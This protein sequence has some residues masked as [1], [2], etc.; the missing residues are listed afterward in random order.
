MAGVLRLFSVMRWRDIERAVSRGG[1][2]VY[3][4]DPVLV[5]SCLDGDERAWAELVQHY[6]RLVYSL[7][8]RYGLS[9]A[10][11]ED[12]LQ[13]VFSIVLRELKTLRNYTRLSGWLITITHHETFRQKS[14][15]RQAGLEE[16]PIVEIPLS[17]DDVSRWEREELMR[18][19]L[20]RLAP[21]E[22]EIVMSVFA[23]DPPSHD[24]LA[25]RL[26][27]PRGSIGPTR[28]RCLRK[29]ETIL[30]EMGIDRDL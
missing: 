5:Q 25:A 11:A 8:R 14:R 19:A 13:N 26:G 10:D 1:S 16:P 24:E 22:S 21:L 18:Q 23:Q 6:A 9:A 3:R 7:P 17:D 20:E 30:T 15:G 29:L 4:N 27:I 12:V 28:G 2:R